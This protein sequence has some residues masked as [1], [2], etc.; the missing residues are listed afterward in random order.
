MI[1]DA[2]VEVTC[3]ECSEFEQHQLTATGRGYDDRNLERQLEREG[4]E[5][6]GDET[7]CPDCIENR[8]LDI[9]PECHQE[10]H[11]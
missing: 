10:V 9:C 7:I 11:G 6:N 1:S 3:D 8:T 2:Y 4:W 5:V